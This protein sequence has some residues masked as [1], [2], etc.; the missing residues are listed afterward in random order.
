MN[1]NAAGDA[2]ML[3]V[4][5]APHDAAFAA[6]ARVALCALKSPDQ[7]A[8]EVLADAGG[9]PQLRLQRGR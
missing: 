4:D 8:V 3:V 6:K 9:Q 5:G 2:H 1:S 7:P